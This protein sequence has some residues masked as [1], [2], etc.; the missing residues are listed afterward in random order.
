MAV[1]RFSEVKVGDKL[2]AIS[3]VVSQEVIDHYAVGSLDYNPVHTDI[4]WA[5]RSQV[6]GLPKTVGHGMFTMSMMA[7]VILRGWG[8]DK[9]HVK[10]VEAKFTKPVEVGE[11]LKC[12]GYV[13]ELHFAGPGRNYVRV[14]LKA[15]T[16][17][18]DTVAVGHAEVVLPD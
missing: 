13:K 8:S 1:P 14:D 16:N 11:E 2:P 3:H 18:A 17:D 4:E 7:S 9:L 5:E 10:T 12:E 6:F 15:V